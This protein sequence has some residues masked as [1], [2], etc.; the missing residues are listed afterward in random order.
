M[1]EIEEPRQDRMPGRGLLLVLFGDS[2]SST[3]KDT[4]SDWR[5]A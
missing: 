1:I 3:Q 2:T 5:T 4:Y